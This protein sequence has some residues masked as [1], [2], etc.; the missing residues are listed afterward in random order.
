MH[1]DVG[2]PGKAHRPR[3]ARGFALVEVLICALLLALAAAT[4]GA[5]L[6]SAWVAAAAAAQGSRAVGAVGDLAESLRA[7]GAAG[8]AAEAAAWRERVAREAG[9]ATVAGPD[10][11]AG[12]GES[13]W[14]ADVGWPDRLA[15]PLR[16]AQPIGVA[17]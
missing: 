6:R 5:G 10:A 8:R 4:L 12:A 14:R 13:I 16:I 3:A 7:V 15:A 9:D 2:G 17:P 11:G 1:R